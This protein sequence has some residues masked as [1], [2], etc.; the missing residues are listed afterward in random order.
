VLVLSEHFGDAP[1][2]EGYQDGWAVVQDTPYAFKTRAD[3]LADASCAT[4]RGQ[5]NAPMF[6]V[7][8]WVPSQT[9]SQSI[10]AD[11]NAYDA[12]LARVRRCQQLRGLFPNII[13][14]DFSEKGDLF[15]V[16]D[17]VNGVGESK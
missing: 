8:N 1:R 12:L 17:A 6:L 7:N 11:V 4:N 16:V 15:R 3:L 10:A 9:P 2:P 5:G 14:V 13:A